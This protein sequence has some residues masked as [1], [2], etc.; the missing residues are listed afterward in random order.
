M[1]TNENEPSDLPFHLL[2]AYAD[3]SEASSPS[4]PADL[5][6]ARPASLGDRLAFA[7]LSGSLPLGLLS[8]VALWICSR[9][10]RW[11]VGASALLLLPLL[12]W[13]LAPLVRSG[14]TVKP[15]KLAASA[16]PLFAGCAAAGLGSAALDHSLTGHPL[17]LEFLAQTLQDELQGLTP[18]GTAAYAVAVGLV[19]AVAPWL[20]ERYPWVDGART[21]AL[22]WRWRMSA[23]FL[24]IVG[25]A[26]GLYSVAALDSSEE[27]WKAVAEERYERRPIVALPDKSAT[28]R[29]AVPPTGPALV[30]ALDALLFERQPVT[31]MAEWESAH[32]AMV[33]VSGSREA[34]AL[35]MLV[36]GRLALLM[37]PDERADFRG[38]VNEFVIPYLSQEPLTVPQMERWLERV[39]TVYPDIPTSEQV[40]DVTA[41]YVLWQRPSALESNK[42]FGWRLDHAYDTLKPG[43]TAPDWHYQGAFQ[44]TPLKIFGRE[45]SWSPTRMADRWIRRKLTRQWLEVRSEVSASDYRGYGWH[46][47]QEMQPGG[48]VAGKFWSRMSRAAN[49]GRDRHALRTAELLLELR[50]YRAERGH[51]PENLSELKREVTYQEGFDRYYSLISKDGKLALHNEDIDRDIVLPAGDQ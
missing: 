30:P 15:L 4:L 31:S 29:W 45:F 25:T 47:S 46:K 17:H 50:L 6:T 14:Q 49:V 40:G 11:E 38:M 19:A 39:R 28:D 48:G 35:A 10:L 7:G 1:S 3:E 42:R 43:R 18:A 34:E 12:V 21:S 23:L 9:S 32:S 8:L 44:P 22:S 2:A 37:L 27:E 41:Y 5:S 26:W 33:A 13:F 16:A 51:Y 20:A 24:A 36:Q